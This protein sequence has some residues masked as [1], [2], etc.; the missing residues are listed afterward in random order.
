MGGPVSALKKHSK[1]YL[2][3]NP[4]PTTK[5]EISKKLAKIFNTSSESISK[6]LPPGGATITDS[7]GIEV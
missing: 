2:I 4:G 7:Y 6:E 1:K 3:L 5:N